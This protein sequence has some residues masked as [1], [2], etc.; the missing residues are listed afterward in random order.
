MKTYILIHPIQ[1]ATKRSLTVAR[2]TALVWS[3]NEKARCWHIPPGSNASSRA[4]PSTPFMLRPISNLPFMP[5]PIIANCFFLRRMKYPFLGTISNFPNFSIF[6]LPLRKQG[7]DRL[8]ACIQIRY[9]ISDWRTVNLCGALSVRF[10]DEMY[11]GIR[12]PISELKCLS[13]HISNFAMLGETTL[14]NYFT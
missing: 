8:I 4:V 3:Y 6:S 11:Q 2:W 1:I 5:G 12:T 7:A 14:L 9:K 13:E 10:F